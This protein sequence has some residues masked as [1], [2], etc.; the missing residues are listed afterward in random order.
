MACSPH[1]KKRSLGTN[2]CHCRLRSA[3]KYATAHPPPKCLA[4]RKNALHLSYLRNPRKRGSL[5]VP[6]SL[7]PKEPVDAWFLANSETRDRR[8]RQC[9]SEGT[10]ITQLPLALD[11]DGKQMASHRCLLHSVTPSCGV[12]ALSQAGAMWKSR[13][14]VARRHR[15]IDKCNGRHQGKGM[16]KASRVSRSSVGN[17]TKDGPCSRPVEREL[18]LTIVSFKRR[19]PR[20]DG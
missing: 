6:C 10:C 15:W 19:G 13:R 12:V 2:R 4:R 20:K 16:R 7:G 9:D 3:V 17:V 14:L 11:T 8:S 18:G 5:A 1:D